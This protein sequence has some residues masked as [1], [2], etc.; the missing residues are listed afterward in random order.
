LLAENAAYKKQIETLKSTN[1][2]LISKN[3]SCMSQISELK[4][5]NADFEGR[6]NEIMVRGDAMSTTYISER[7]R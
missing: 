3:L 5:K 7:V 6:I 1:V 2:E 4:N